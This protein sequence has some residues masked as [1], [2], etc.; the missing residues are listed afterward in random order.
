[1]YECDIC[2]SRISLKKDLKSH[3]K[4]VH[5]IIY[6]VNVEHTY[7]IN[8]NTKHKCPV[9]SLVFVERSSLRRHEKLKHN[10]IFTQTLRSKK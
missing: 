1:M 10:I 2:K 5:D 9:C 3:M 6:K 4:N 7:S 8:E